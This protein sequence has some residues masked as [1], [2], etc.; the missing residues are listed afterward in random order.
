MNFG[1]TLSFGSDLNLAPSRHLANACESSLANTNQP[2]LADDRLLRSELEVELEQ[3]DE[4]PIKEIGAL[5]L[6]AK[7]LGDPILKCL[8]RIVWRTEPRRSTWMHCQLS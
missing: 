7:L 5:C 1:R 2:L 4:A 6:H 8:F 3:S